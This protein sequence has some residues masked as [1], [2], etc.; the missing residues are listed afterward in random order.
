MFRFFDTDL[1]HRVK[2]ILEAGAA[3]RV[4]STEFV[5]IRLVLLRYFWVNRAN[6]L[7]CMTSV[8]SYLVSSC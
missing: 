5:N 2:E 1:K 8:A 7:I 3:E 4:N 6:I